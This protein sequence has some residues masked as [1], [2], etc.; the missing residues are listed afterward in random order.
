MQSSK[1]AQ[2]PTV[3]RVMSHTRD[4]D[5]VLSLCQFSDKL[6]K[7]VVSPGLQSLTGKATMTFFIDGMGEYHRQVDISDSVFQE[8]R[9]TQGNTIGHC[10][11]SNFSFYKEGFYSRKSCHNHYYF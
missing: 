11:L 3:V 10:G 2:S 6:N 5:F 9:A 4:A 7:M 8:P 1:S